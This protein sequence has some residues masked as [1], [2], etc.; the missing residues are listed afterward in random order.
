MARSHEARLEEIMKDRTTRREFFKTSAGV[1]A[2]ATLPS[3]R[4]SRPV[5]VPAKA[6]TH[7]VNSSGNPWVPAPAGTTAV[8]A[9]P[10]ADPLPIKQGVLVG[11]LPE[12]KRYDDRV[13]H[14]GAAGLAVM[15]DTQHVAT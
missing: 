10:A 12:N 11:M 8:I 6:G 5:V 3:T 9:N 1:A 7:G 2:G 15:H 14:A 4:H 13:D